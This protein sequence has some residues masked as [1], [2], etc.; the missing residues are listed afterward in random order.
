MRQCETNSPGEFR[1]ALDKQTVT[2]IEALALLSS[3]I[4]F[5]VRLPSIAKELTAGYMLCIS[6]IDK[7]RVLLKTFQSSEPMLA[8]FSQ[9]KCR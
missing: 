4:N 3:W 9:Q 8:L 7:T 5:D 6:S 2:E 1:A